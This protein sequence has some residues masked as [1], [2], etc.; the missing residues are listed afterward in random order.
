MRRSSLLALLLVTPIGFAAKFYAGPGASWVAPYGAGV[1][2]EV[3]W[4]LVVSAMWPRLPVLRVAIGVFAATCFLEVLQLWR[5]PPLEALRSSFLGRAL[6]GSTFSW[7]D[8]PHY[9]AGAT[10]GF[11][12][13][14]AFADRATRGAG[15]SASV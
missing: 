7:W 15:R 14:R 9:A 10:A 8:F 11:V 5:P 1:L 2:Y 3:F 13:V 4:I 12:L 6:V